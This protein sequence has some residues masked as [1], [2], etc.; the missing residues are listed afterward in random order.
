MFGIRTRSNGDFYWVLKAP[1]G[2][3]IAQS[4]GDYSS[5]AAV[6]N[7]IASVK[8]VAEY[9][10]IE[11]NSLTNKTSNMETVNQFSPHAGTL[12]FSREQLVLF[13]EYLL[14]DERKQLF[15]SHP[16]AGDSNLEYRL[17]Q[18]H[19]SDVENFVNKYASFGTIPPMPQDKLERIFNAVVQWQGETFG[20]GR[21]ALYPVNHLKREVKELAEA[22]EFLDRENPREFDVQS[23]ENSIRKEFAD[24]FMLLFNA[25]NNFGF[26][27]HDICAIIEH[28]LDINRTREWGEAD[29]EGVVTHTKPGHGE[30][31]TTSSD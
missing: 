11:N 27:Y 15:A 24:C 20:F 30:E 14:S 23:H 12:G 28:K 13:G 1:N 16:T 19:H 17:S 7:S 5:M 10:P 9:A 22:L 3:P 26:N 29:A 8:K 6:E 25:A 4:Y 31:D 21:P 18:V 2:Q